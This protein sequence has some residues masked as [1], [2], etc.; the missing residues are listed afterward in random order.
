MLIGAFSRGRFLRLTRAVGAEPCSTLWHKRHD[1]V[2]SKD[3]TGLANAKNTGQ[4]LDA[5]S[6][7]G[8]SYALRQACFVTI[9]P[10]PG[11]PT[12]GPLRVASVR[13]LVRLLVDAADPP[14]GPGWSGL[15]GAAAEESRRLPRNF[16]LPCR[17]QR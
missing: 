7:M 1:A 10:A 9:S 2:W 14:A 8:H 16:V 15:M 5:H 4:G 3:A 17:R 6:A 11:E 13:E 12:A